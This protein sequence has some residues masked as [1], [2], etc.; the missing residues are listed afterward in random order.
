MGKSRSDDKPADTIHFLCSCGH[1]FEATP[2]RVEDAEERPWHP[3][4]YY[5]TCPHCSH[6]AA[7]A[8]WEVNIF[9][10][11]SHATGP[12]SPEGRAASAANLKGHPTPQ[13]AQFTRLNALKH[14]SYA[15]TSMF[16]P[17]R[18]GR[19]PQCDECIHLE[20]ETCLPYRVCLSKVEVFA[21]FAAAFQSGDPSVIKTIVG[22]RQ[23]AFQTIMD[24][25][26]YLLARDGVDL[27]APVWHGDKDGGVHFV[28][29]LNPETEEEEQLLE[30]SEHPLLK[31]LIEML[32]KN[33]MALGDMSMTPKA[34]DEQEIMQG[35]LSNE[36]N[37]KQ[38]A[39]EFQ[40]KSIDQV[41]KLEQL[42]KNSLDES[43][44]RDITDQ[45][46]VSRV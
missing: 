18:P 40:Q 33:N 43:G 9:K 15:N 20:D 44:G 6:E 41:A 11:H 13:E 35:F 1:R 3:W 19:Y 36:E 12:T 42:I 22:H 23:A 27:V 16:F 32:A 5:A 30:H 24:E 38:S 7:Q 21:K 4:A 39:L 26:I 8:A 46:E 45:V 25:I 28:K 29:Y 37:E 14:G 10:A 2:E 17:A 34:Q 31:R